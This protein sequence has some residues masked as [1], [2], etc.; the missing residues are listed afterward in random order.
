[1]ST[2]II[3]GAA[4]GIGESLAKLLSNDHKLILTYHSSK[5]N[6]ISNADYYQLDLNSEKEILNFSQIIKTKYNQIDILINN[7]AVCHDKKFINT[8]FTE[9]NQQ[10]NVNLS[11]L[12]KLSLN[13]LPIIK[14]KIINIGSECSKEIYPEYAVYTATKFAVRAFTQVLAKEES[15]IHTYCV[16]PGPTATKMNGFFG[17]EVT[18]IAQ[19]I[20]DQTINTTPQSGSDIDLYKQ[21]KNL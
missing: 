11:A 4:T 10:I 6:R 20:I 5:P 9:I 8:N 19:A 7:A 14:Q 16:N 17:T 12:I 21:F 15:G 1:M 13:L 3:T 18:K 2:I